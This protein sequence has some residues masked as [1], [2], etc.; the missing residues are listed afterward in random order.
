MFTTGESAHGCGHAVRCINAGVRTCSTDYLSATK[1]SDRL[2]VVT[3]QYVDKILTYRD[4]EDD[5]RAS[6]VLTRN[7]NG[8][9]ITYK[10]RREVTL[11]AGAY[12]SPA[13]LLRSGIGSSI[14]LNKID[15][16]SVLELPGVGKNLT[17]HLVS[18][19]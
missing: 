2:N 10:A 8:E 9:E 6:A 5:I 15:V 14:D 11:T 17:D 12:G 19:H 7:V 13:I 4:A 3:G 16:N 18:A 1:A